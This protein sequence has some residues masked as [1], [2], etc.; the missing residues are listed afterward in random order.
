MVSFFQSQIYS[1]PFEFFSSINKRVDLS[2][3]RANK[4]ISVQPLNCPTFANMIE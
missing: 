1:I 4:Q 3:N 2:N